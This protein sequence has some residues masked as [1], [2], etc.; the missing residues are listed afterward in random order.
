MYFA[1]K[2]GVSPMVFKKKKKTL[3]GFPIRYNI[4][5]PQPTKRDGNRLSKVGNI[6]QVNF[7]I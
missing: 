5:P 1:T 4:A 6:G 2:K 3:Q 7:N